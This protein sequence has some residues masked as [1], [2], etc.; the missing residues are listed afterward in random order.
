MTKFLDNVDRSVMNL[1]M[2]N[3]TKKDIKCIAACLKVNTFITTLNLN[4]NR[5]G[6]AGMSYISD[7]LSDNRHLQHLIVSDN[8]LTRKSAEGLITNLLNNTSITAL[9]LNNNNLGDTLCECLCWLY[10]RSLKDLRLSNNGVT[11]SGSLLLAQTLEVNR[12]FTALDL[13]WNSISD[14]G[15]IAVVNQLKS[16][17]IAWLDLSFTG[18]TDS[19]G[20]VV[21]TSLLG[22]K[23]TLT[24]INLGH[25]RITN[26]TINAITKA[27]DSNTGLK[28]AHIDISSNKISLSSLLPLLDAI[29]RVKSMKQLHLQGALHG[30]LEENRIAERAI[31][32]L[33]EARN[34]IHVVM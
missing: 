30:T 13:S 15:C 24:F 12:H 21:V 29:G 18:I 23:S 28:L 10:G 33:R 5:M 20:C 8:V 11:K 2:A 26:T 6:D 22:P 17:P 34:D 27:L 3:L 9:N 32:K 4:C 7:M 31:E 1:S 19:G 14:E 16:C 25:N